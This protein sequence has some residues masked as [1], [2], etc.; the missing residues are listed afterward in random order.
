MFDIS[1]LNFKKLFEMSEGEPE[2]IGAGPVLTETPVETPQEEGTTYKVPYT[3]I[4]DIQPHNNAERLEVATV[5][6]FQVVVSKGRYKVGDKAVYI[7]IDS[8]LPVNLE[9]ILFP[10]DAKIKLHHHRVRQIKIRGLASQGMLINP[11]EITSLVNPKYFKDEQDL[12]L[13]LGVTKYEPPVK[14][15]HVAGP[16][17]QRKKKHENPLF[18]K[19]N[20]LDNIKWFPNKFTELTE[21]VIQEKLHGTNARAS[22]MPYSAHSWFRKIK[23]FL[24]LTPKNENCYGSNNVEI[25]AK[26]TYKGF[27]G[28]DVY[29]KV[30]NSIDVF[31]KIK[32]GESVF[33]EIVGPGIQKNYGYGLKEH[34]FVLFDVKVLQADKTQ[35][36][37]SPDEV[38]AFAKERGFDFVPVLYKG[39]YNKELSYSLTK[40][41]SEYNDKSEKVRE[42]IVIKAAK[43][44]TIEGNKQALKWVSEEYLNDPT[45]TDD[46]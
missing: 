41:K 31:N 28:E 42:G 20:G 32:L 18:H 9:E 1:K 2:V 35:V 10:A 19:Y 29:G 22:I 30:F 11:D 27:Y 46:H 8:I 43:D 37:L 13:V 15:I 38:E 26:T 14:Q 3:S 21:V 44:Y 24:G 39:P 17:G 25:S 45:N 5:Y 23:Q 6:G 12:K 36:W 40:G 4:L 34:K 33:G 7:P 16:P